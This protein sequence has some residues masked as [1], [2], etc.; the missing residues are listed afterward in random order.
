MSASAVSRV[1][2]LAWF[3]EDEDREVGEQGTSNRDP[4]TLATRQRRAV[5]P[6]GSVEAERERRDPVTQAR[7]RECGEQ[8]G[9][10]RA[11]L[12]EAKVLAQRRV[13]DV[14]VLLDEADDVADLLA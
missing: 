8:L 5:L 12:R 1:E 4:L 7:L 6:D 2:M 3:V 9:V 11:G 14:C 13:E 10:G